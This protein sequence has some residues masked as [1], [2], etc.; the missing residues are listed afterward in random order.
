MSENFNLSLRKDK[1]SLT[2]LI[3]RVKDI[4]IFKIDLSMIDLLILVYVINANI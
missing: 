3:C 1:F 4:I 2:G